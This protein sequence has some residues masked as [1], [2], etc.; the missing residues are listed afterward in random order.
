MCSNSP[1]RKFIR[2]R[3]IIKIRQTLVFQPEDV[4]AGFIPTDYLVIVESA[5]AL[6]FQALPGV[7]PGI[8]TLR[9]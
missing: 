9:L 1:N 2:L 7:S 5:P 6:N 4:Q 8:P 3:K